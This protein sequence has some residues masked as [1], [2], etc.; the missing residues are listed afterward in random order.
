MQVSNT[1]PFDEPPLDRETHQQRRRKLLRIDRLSKLFHGDL[2]TAFII[3]REPIHQ[4]AQL[5]RAL[6]AFP[7][8]LD[9]ASVDFLHTP[10]QMVR[11]LFRERFGI[12]EPRVWVFE[13][14]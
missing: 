14:T 8:P 7:P 9:D 1:E 2:Q 13:R 10:T 11:K 3:Q 5:T 6:A 4:R 12:H